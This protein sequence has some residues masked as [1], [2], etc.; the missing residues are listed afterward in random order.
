[1]EEEKYIKKEKKRILIIFFLIIFLPILFYIIVVLLP[2]YI[3]EKEINMGF[4]DLN[5]Y[6]LI[7]EK[8]EIVNLAEI[9]QFDWERAYITENTKELYDELDKI[10]GINC[11]LP[12]LDEDLRNLE[13]IFIN[14]EDCVY[15]FVYDYMYIKFTSPGTFI[16][17]D[18][19][20]LKKTKKLKKII[21]EPIN[22]DKIRR[23]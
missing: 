19:A 23:K 14:K 16:Y 9:F 12:P 5:Y 17:R 20:N 3:Y 18:E 2:I 1:V 6:N 8:D 10:L 7:K 11:N 21:L 4:K 15:E 22:S 13:V